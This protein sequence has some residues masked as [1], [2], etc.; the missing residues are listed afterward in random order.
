MLEHS[1]TYTVGKRGAIYDESFEG[2]KSK[3]SLLF[4]T[5]EFVNI[6]SYMYVHVMFGK[7][8]PKTLMSHDS[9]LSKAQNYSNLDRNLRVIT[10]K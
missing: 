3:K 9:C 4:N 7:N 1:P 2:K 6:D 10:F 5:N 8:L